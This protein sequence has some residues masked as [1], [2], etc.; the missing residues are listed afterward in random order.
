MCEINPD[1]AY[2]VSISVS[3]GFPYMVSVSPC[4]PY[5]VS[6]FPC[7]SYMVMLPKHLSVKAIFVDRAL[8]WVAM[9]VALSQGPQLGRLN[10]KTVF[11]FMECARIWAGAPNTLSSCWLGAAI[12]YA[13]M[14][15]RLFVKSYNLSFKSSLLLLQIMFVCTMIKGILCGEAIRLGRYPLVEHRW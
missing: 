7:F 11:V 15:K 12:D 3:L 1:T 9:N 5:M 10:D 6:V 14:G 13:C 4:F 8:L 2:V